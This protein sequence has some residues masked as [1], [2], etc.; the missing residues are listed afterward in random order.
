MTKIESDIFVKFPKNKFLSLNDNEHLNN[1]AFIYRNALGRLNNCVWIDLS[2]SAMLLIGC[3][4]FSVLQNL[5]KL[6]L[7]LLTFFMDFQQ[8]RLKLNCLKELNYT[9][10]QELNFG[11]ITF[12]SVE[13]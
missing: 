11:R 1:F 7:S 5:V 9:K 3:M 10:I 2:H 8:R 4:T 6:D 13:N 12:E